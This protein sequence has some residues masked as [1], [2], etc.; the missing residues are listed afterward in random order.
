L[1]ASSHRT[2]SSINLPPRHCLHNLRLSDF[3]RLVHLRRSR[4]VSRS[5][6]DC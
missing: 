3:E 1:F 4:D 5:T 6:C 2:A